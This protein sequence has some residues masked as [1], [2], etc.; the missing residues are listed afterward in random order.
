MLLATATAGPRPGGFL[1]IDPEWKGE[2]AFLICGGPS[3]LGQ[4]LEQLRGRR[5]V[6]VNSSVYT[7]PWADILFFGDE[8]WEVNNRA[9]VKAFK[10]RVL[11]SCYGDK[12]CGYIEF[13]RR[14]RPSDV[15]AGL[16]ADPSQAW[17]RHTS[18][19]GAIN[20]LCHLGV[21]TIV[22]LGLDGGPDHSG[23]TH[24]H[25]PHPWG[26]NKDIWA[27]QRE[28]LAAVAPALKGRGIELLNASP[29]SKIPFWPIVDL[30]SCL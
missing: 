20:V 30:E 14:P 16:S 17:M 4:D 9:A 18:V 8:R 5:V 21:S 24:H 23:K 22:T 25:E 28:E 10:G 26:M 19:R 7:M 13:L 27:L 11:S 12:H 15:P 3:V 6:V 29:G 1:R 2:T